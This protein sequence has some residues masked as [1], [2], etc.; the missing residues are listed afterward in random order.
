MKTI[1]EQIAELLL[2]ILQSEIVNKTAGIE[3]GYRS[4]SVELG[5][6]HN[7]P[8]A[9]VCIYAGGACTDIFRGNDI[10]A[11]IEA[12]R[13]FNP[14]QKR[15]NAIAKLKAELAALEDTK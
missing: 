3:E 10:D 14:E 11:A 15:L 6:F 2:P 7:G 1:T 8:K 13:Q 9:E 12:V 4:I 5:I